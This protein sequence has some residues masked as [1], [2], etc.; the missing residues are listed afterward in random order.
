[1]S[2]PHLF[3]TATADKP[4]TLL[5]L[6]LGVALSWAG[7]PALGTAAIGAAGALASQG[8]LRLWA[9]LVVG[10]LGS[11]L[12][13]M[14]GWWLGKHVVGVGLDRGEGRFVDRRRAAMESGRHFG[15]RWG[16]FM[17]FFVPSWVP[18]A[19]DVPFGVFTRWNLLA[20]ALWTLG[21]SLSAYGITEAVK[22]HS[23]VDSALPIAIAVLALTAIAVLGFRR[24]R[25]RASVELDQSSEGVA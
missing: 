1:M 12:G 4:E 10:T 22:G 16:K 11:E 17:V 2:V 8:D 13:G 23:L 5:I 24:R 15:E 18:G 7:V 14:G 21:A 20:A 25:R 9:V 6:F 3:A 19:L